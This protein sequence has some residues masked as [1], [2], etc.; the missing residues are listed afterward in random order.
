MTIGQAARFEGVICVRRNQF[1][2]R[3]PHFPSAPF[4][5]LWLYIEWKYFKLITRD[6]M[7]LRVSYSEL[8]NTIT[9]VEPLK[10]HSTCLH[11]LCCVRLWVSLIIMSQ[12]IVLINGVPNVIIKSA[13]LWE[14]QIQ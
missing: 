6:H 11:L 9:S 10:Q 7:L 5:G 8:A 4:C 3:V 12:S 14:R 2:G 13:N 1:S